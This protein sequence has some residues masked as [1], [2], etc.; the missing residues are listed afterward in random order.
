MVSIS[1]IIPV[2]NAE[3]Y[4]SACLNSVINQKF[5]ELEIILIDDGSTDNSGKIC[6]D[7]SKKDNR[8]KVI[9]KKNEGVSVAR[10]IGLD[11]AKGKWISFVDS[12][13]IIEEDLYKRIICELEKND[14][15]V[16]IFNHFYNNKK[17][18]LYSSEGIIEEKKIINNVKEKI[19]Y[20]GFD[21]ETPRVYSFVW[22][23]IFKTELIK[24]NNIRFLMENKKAIFEDGLFCID[25]LEHSNKI[26]ISNEYLYHYIKHKGSAMNTFNND[27]LDIN[28]IIFDK[29][30]N[31]CSEKSFNFRVIRQFILLCNLCLLKKKEINA[32]DIINKTIKQSPYYESIVQKNKDIKLSIKQEI[33]LF[34]VKKRYIKLLKIL[35]N[36]S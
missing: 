30:K 22:N 25:A 5:K 13:D 2:Y 9:H 15:D 32:K 29:L 27:M 20:P 34:L 8:V 4:L 35:C 19:I 23:K 24:K 17:N 14:P 12:D 18:S 21:I 28:N 1:V 31:N 3:R 7:F 10:N 11:I 26:Q 6:D 16:F 33:Y 36:I